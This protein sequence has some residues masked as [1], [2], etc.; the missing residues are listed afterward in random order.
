MASV[1]TP[2]DF[3]LMQ[4]HRTTPSEQK[5]STSS[6]RNAS[7]CIIT[8]SLTHQFLH[9]QHY[10]LLL[11]FRWTHGSIGPLAAPISRR[12]VVTGHKHVAIAAHLSGTSHSAGP[13]PHDLRVMATLVVVSTGIAVVVVP[14]FFAHPRIR[15]LP[16][17]PWLPGAPEDI[18]SVRSSRVL[19]P[20]VSVDLPF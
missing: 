2:I 12:A 4:A 17:L 20:T 3:T 14:L 15:S 6:S 10:I 18:L 1:G 19:Q 5:S 9:T 16:G 8:N 13:P 7:D 11:A